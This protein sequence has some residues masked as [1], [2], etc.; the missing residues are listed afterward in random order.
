M[1]NKHMKRYSVS[2][3][4]R[5]MQNTTPVKCHLIPVR[6]ATSIEIGIA[7]R[8]H[9]HGWQEGEWVP[10]LC[11]TIWQPLDMLQRLAP[12]QP[13]DLA[14]GINLWNLL[15]ISAELNLVKS[16]NSLSAHQGKMNA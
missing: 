2:L 10:I 13:R 15:L 9:L 16:L 7:E 1:T 4:L 3:R 8:T 11:K 14:S 6:L 5:K 12:Q